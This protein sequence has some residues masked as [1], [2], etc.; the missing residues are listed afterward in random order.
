MDP[1]TIG[2]G[3]ASLGGQLFGAIKGGQANNANEALLKQREEE[4]NALFKSR[5]NRD[6]LQT[7][8][9]KGVLEKIRKQYENADKGIAGRAAITGAS[10]EAVVAQKTA[11]NENLND[12]TSNIAQGATAYQDNAENQFEQSKNAMLSAK[13]GVNSAKAANAA[14]L[15]SNAG[16]LLGT[17]AMVHGMGG[18]K[19]LKENIDAS[20]NSVFRV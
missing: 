17:A 18:L 6:F 2:L 1:L 12:A 15:A 9:A 7:N 19:G 14:N 13:M 3:V 11:N 8:A 4:S 10:D 20:N 16:N 5:I